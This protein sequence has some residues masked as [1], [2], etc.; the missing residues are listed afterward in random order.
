MP[1]EDEIMWSTSRLPE[2]LEPTEYA[3]RLDRACEESGSDL[4][5]LTESN[6]TRLFP[7]HREAVGEAFVEAARRA[8]SSAYEPNPRGLVEAREG[9]C[10]YYAARG[11][12]LDPSQVTVTAS[13]SE[14]YAWLAKVLTDAGSEVLVPT[15]SYPLFEHLMRMENVDVV[16]HRFRY[17]GT[18]S[19]DFGDL[20]RRLDACDDPRALFQVS[21]NNPTGHVM[22]AEEFAR[23]GAICAERNLALVVDEVF[24]DFGLDT[25]APVSTVERFQ[26]NPDVRPPVCFTLAGL[27]K[28]AG[29]PGAKFGWIVTQGDRSTL[30]GATSRLEFIADNFL[31]ASTVSQLLAA[32]VL[33]DLESFQEAVRSR[34]R[35]NLSRLRTAFADDAACEVYPADA[36]WYGVVRIPRVV[37]PQTFTL[38]LVRRDDV[39]VQPGFLYDFE[40]GVHLVASLLPPPDDFDAG[41]ER[42]RR[43]VAHRLAELSED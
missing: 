30:P 6:P 3:R 23:L 42:I 36:G 16:S 12:E 38:E 32:T 43:S 13:T 29:L 4:I 27:S 11:A 8:A 15:P 20:R 18:W 5:D 40:R 39:L 37:D 17:D 19:L 10:E 1:N 7:E 14:A 35:R 2:R 28:S 24:L 9:V 26:R 22:N 41:V 25:E 34:T 21:P 33:S 31:S